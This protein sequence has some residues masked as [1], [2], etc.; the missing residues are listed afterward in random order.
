MEPCRCENLNFSDSASFDDELK[1]KLLRYI[2]F[3]T[4]KN[5]QQLET[6]AFGQCCPE[7]KI[8]YP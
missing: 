3:L 1:T 4:N 8:K 5:N 6:S 2:Y 7:T